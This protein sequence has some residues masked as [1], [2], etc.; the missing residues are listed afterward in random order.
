MPTPRCAAA[1]ILTEHSSGTKFRTKQ[2]KKPDERPKNTPG[3]KTENIF[4]K[5]VGTSS[6]PNILPS[7]RAGFADN[8]ISATSIAM[9]GKTK[10]R[11]E[12]QR[13][14]GREYA[15]IPAH[16]YIYSILGEYPA[17]WGGD[18]PSPERRCF[19]RGAEDGEAPF[20]H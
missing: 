19:P 1:T 9:R 13:S 10:I 12:E 7:T 2:K 18:E 6:A 17:P 4:T 15:M 3:K 11:K 8:G 16:I 20:S 5:L 14:D